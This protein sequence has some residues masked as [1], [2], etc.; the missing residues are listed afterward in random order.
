M[1]IKGLGYFKRS[2]ENQQDFI[3]LKKFEKNQKK[4]LTKGFW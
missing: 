1:I 4:V 3:F 2:S